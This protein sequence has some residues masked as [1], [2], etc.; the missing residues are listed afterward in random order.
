M[1]RLPTHLARLR[2]ALVLLLALAPG[3]AIAAS[4]TA[5]VSPTN[6]IDGDTVELVLSLTDGDGKQPPNLSA[7][8]RDFDVVEQGRR[9]RPVTE[10]G[11]RVTVNEWLITLAPKRSGKLVIPQLAVAG[12]LSQPLTITV[13]PSATATQDMDEKPLFVRLEAGDVSPFVQSD[14]P[15]SVRVYARI[16]MLGGGLSPPEADGAA[17]TP[18][19]EQRQYARAIGK[20]RYQVIEQN[21]LMRPQRSGTITVKPVTL[22]AR[23]VSYSGNEASD[24]MARMLGRPPGTMPW[25]NTPTATREMITESNPLTIT[26]RERPADAKGW[27]LPARR[28]AISSEW[29]TPLKDAKV[30]SVLSRTIRLEAVGAG[31]NQLPPLTP[32]DVAGIRQYVE[33][34][35]SESAPI[36][37]EQGAL[38]TQTVSVVPTRAGTYTLPAIE[39][40]WW[41]TATQQQQTAVLPAETFTVA[42]DPRAMAQEPPTPV[43]STTAPPPGATPTPPPVAAP[44]SDRMADVWAF[45]LRH[46]EIIGSVLGAAIVLF[47]LGYLGRWLR[48]A[49]AARKRNAPVAV[50]APATPSRANALRDPE[51]AEQALINACKAKDAGAAHRAVLAWLRLSGGAGTPVSPDLERALGTLR[52][53]VYGETPARFDGGSFLKAFRAEQKARGAKPKA[54]RGAKLAPLYPS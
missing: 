17:F 35:R 33:T 15:V 5:T 30:G 52:T 41:N 51:A 16:D 2:A 38:L 10:N 34:N 49:I 28:V 47:A 37:G 11:R 53:S 9:S 32:A 46:R 22:R 31:P 25:M 26:V 3:L 20:F 45:L 48:G 29:T 14:I 42:P 39:V 4:L 12:L 18:Q 40:A 6:I 13:V 44:A 1:M 19:G 8:T 50:T 24:A 27:F 7:L 43:T 21:Y 23:V 36:R 54:V